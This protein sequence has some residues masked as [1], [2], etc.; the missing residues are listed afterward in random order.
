MVNH[1]NE[2]K[3]IHNISYVNIRIAHEVI[4]CS[5]VFIDKI[6]NRQKTNIYNTLIVSPP[7][8][9]KTTYLR[10]MIRS[11]SN[12]EYGVGLTVGIVD[13]RSEIAACDKGVGQKK[14]KKK[15]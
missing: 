7:C 8:M 3:N 12:G 13:E 1:E 9:G 15:K 14:V 2:I 11:I 5:K 4:G 10:D 6:Y